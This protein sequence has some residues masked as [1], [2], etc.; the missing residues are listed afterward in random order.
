MRYYP[1]VSLYTTQTTLTSPVAPFHIIKSQVTQKASEQTAG[2]FSCYSITDAAGRNYYLP[3][4]LS[5]SSSLGW[6]SSY[7]VASC[8]RSSKQLQFPCKL[9]PALPLSSLS[10]SF[11]L[12]L[13][14][15]QVRR[16][17]RHPGHT[18]CLFAMEETPH[19]L[20][21]GI[22]GASYTIRGRFG[23]FLLCP[24]PV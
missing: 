8:K 15:A 1:L 7:R 22:H 23:G 24:A 10:L 2:P 13:A 14:T 6:A 12:S 17:S 11:S 20:R 5:L 18:L 9:P 4:S 21:L 16:G 19:T 3:L